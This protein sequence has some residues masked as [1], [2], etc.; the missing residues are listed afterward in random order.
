MRRDSL[1]E[2]TCAGEPHRRNLAPA[3]TIFKL[4]S[5]AKEEVLAARAQS[6]SF[7]LASARSSGER[8]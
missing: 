7:A 3:N 6:M 8:A 1:D 2:P 4:A 5:I